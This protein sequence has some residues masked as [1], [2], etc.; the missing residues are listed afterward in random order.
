MR[1]AK[2]AQEGGETRFHMIRPSDLF[3]YDP[4]TP[5]RIQESVPTRLEDEFSVGLTYQASSSEVASDVETDVRRGRPD[6]TESPTSATNR[7]RDEN[8]RSGS[9]VVEQ[10]GKTEYVD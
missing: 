7:R 3:A 2:K 1:A 5:P 6:D 10:M 9:R 4:S 8:C